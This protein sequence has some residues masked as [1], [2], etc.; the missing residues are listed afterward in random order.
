MNESEL[1]FIF[2]IAF[3]I[4]F[5]MFIASLLAMG[6]LF[7]QLREVVSLAI[8]KNEEIERHIKKIAE[9]EAVIYDLQRQCASYVDILN[10]QNG[11]K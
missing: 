11:S 8:E 6:W 1:S 10:K 4:S 7:N 3:A 9:Q 5:I 2:G